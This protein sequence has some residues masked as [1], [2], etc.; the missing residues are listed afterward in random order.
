MQKD[1]SRERA[2]YCNCDLARLAILL[3][4]HRAQQTPGWKYERKLQNPPPWVGPRNTK[5]RKKKKNTIIYENGHF[6]AFFFFQFRVE[7]YS[8][9]CLFPAWGVLVLWTSLTESQGKTNFSQNLLFM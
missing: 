9:F 4:S 1:L 6:R 5:K 8:V 7:D 2:M 3:G